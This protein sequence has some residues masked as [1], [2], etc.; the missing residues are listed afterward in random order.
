MFWAPSTITFTMGREHGMFHHEA[1][2]LL[3]IVV[4]RA[5]IDPITPIRAS[6]PEFARIPSMLTAG[7]WERMHHFS[8]IDNTGMCGRNLLSPSSRYSSTET[9]RRVKQSNA[10]ATFQRDCFEIYCSNNAFRVCR[11]EHLTAL[12]RWSGGE[13]IPEKHLGKRWCYTFD[14]GDDTADAEPVVPG[15]K[16]WLKRI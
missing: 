10:V 14:H 13:Q 15:M 1:T 9:G 3:N 11:L 16:Q 4:A 5:A 12:L 2:Q 6:S 7:G 8:Q